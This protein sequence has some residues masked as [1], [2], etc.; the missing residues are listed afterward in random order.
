MTLAV[1]DRGSESEVG[2]R[3]RVKDANTAIYRPRNRLG[4][5]YTTRQI[6]RTQA[7]IC[8]AHLHRSMG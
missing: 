3:V 6:G 7:S 8:C 1:D 2:A 5:G 4:S